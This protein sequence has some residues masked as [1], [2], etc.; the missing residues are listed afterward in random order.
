M[1]TPDQGPTAAFS[2]SPAPTDSPSRFDG[3]ASASSSP[4]ASVASYDLSFGDGSS[5]ADAGPTPSHIYTRPGVYTVTLTVADTGG[6]STHEIYTGQTALCAG[7]AGATTLRTVTI[8]AG[9]PSL[10]RLHESRK[11]WRRG[12]A[13]IRIS[14][15][16]GRSRPFGTSFSFYLSEAASVTVRFVAKSPR[17]RGAE[18]VTLRGRAGANAVFFDGVLAHHKRLGLGGYT[19][20][21]TATASGRTS[22]VSRLSFKVTGG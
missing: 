18:T 9:G 6:C 4:E 13:P 10:T 7:S 15:H 14:T 2:S 3:A 5:A 22:P 16:A 12:S 11:N 17:R 19:A 8:A 20:Y 21:F 1:I